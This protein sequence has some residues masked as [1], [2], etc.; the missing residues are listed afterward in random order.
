MGR[1]QLSPG[2]RMTIAIKK[3]DIQPVIDEIYYSPFVWVPAL[4]VAFFFFGNI[5]EI[6]WLLLRDLRRFLFR[7][8]RYPR[9]FVKGRT[10]K[11]KLF[12]LRRYGKR[13]REDRGSFRGR[14]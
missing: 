11:I 7:M 1:K 12:F 5:F 8:L 14:R 10:D 13:R 3:C 9:H 6:L 4:M 2:A